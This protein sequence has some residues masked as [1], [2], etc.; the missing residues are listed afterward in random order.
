MST[1][2]GLTA[3]DLSIGAIFVALMAIG[4]NITSIAP[5][6][7]IGGVPITLQTFFALLAGLMLGSRLGMISMLV[8]MLLG[9]VGAPIFSQFSGGPSTLLAPTFGFILSYPIIA[10]IIGKIAEKN[11]KLPVYLGASL[12]GLILNYAIG[13]NWMYLAYQVWFEAPEGLTYALVWIWLAVPLPK[14][15]ILAIVGGIFAH[16]LE[17]SFLARSQFRAQTNINNS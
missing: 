4:A 9:L 6:M 10:F 11:R 14:D 2:K 13:A 5:F 8:Y 7:V 15:I 3:L 12:L 1:K 16:R 17:K